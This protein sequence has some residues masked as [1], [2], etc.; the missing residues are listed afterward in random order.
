M[1]Q[2][3]TIER[4]LSEAPPGF[5]P[6]AGCDRKNFRAHFDAHE[7]DDGFSER[8][9]KQRRSSKVAVML[10]QPFTKMERLFFDRKVSRYEL[11]HPPTFLIGHWRSGTTHLH[12]LLYASDQFASIDFGQ[13]AMPHNLLNPTRFIGRAAMSSVIP[14]DRGMDN[15]AMGIRE[16]Q[17]EEMALGN[18]NPISYY[19]VFY[20]PQE[21]RREFDRSIF[22]DG[23]TE[24][25]QNAFEASYVKL[26]RKLS[27]SGK[28]RP[29]LLKNPASTARIEQ[30]DRLF[31]GARFI[32]IV[33]NPFEVFLSMLNHYP[34]LFNAFAWQKFDNV[35]LEEMVFYKY[36]RMMRAYLQQREQL[37]DRLIETSYENIVADPIREIGRLYE[38]FSFGEKDRGLRAI[39][40]YAGTLKGYKRNRYQIRRAQAERIRDEWG[41]ALDEW[42][43]SPD[44]SIEL[45]D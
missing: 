42:G 36:G 20:Y 32:H 40:A 16:P 38:H 45:V 39:S 11:P 26:L 15:V 25:E 27:I 22:M 9:A 24:E 12:N 18:L 21:M 5:H 30:L 17:E 19:N 33:R 14:K 44:E 6:L 34:R 37:G 13:T 3:W 8:T 29:L 31:P 1:S 4:A 2:R 41:F 43:Y 10:R 35:D 23:T 7:G 28:D